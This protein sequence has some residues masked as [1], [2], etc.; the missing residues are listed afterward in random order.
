M[1]VCGRKTRDHVYLESSY[2]FFLPSPPT[3]FRL[4]YSFECRTN[5]QKGNNINIIDFRSSCCFIFILFSCYY[6]LF[7]FSHSQYTWYRYNILKYNTTIN[8]NPLCA[9]IHRYYYCIYTYMLQ[10]LICAIRFFDAKRF[11][12]MIRIL[13]HNRYTFG[14]TLFS[15]KCK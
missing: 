10:C 3:F 8:D 9:C 1:C 12:Y 11:F 13:Y 7:L 4:P 14:S 5:A 2:F 15:C 6:R